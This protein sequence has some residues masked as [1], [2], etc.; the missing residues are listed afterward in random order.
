MKNNMKAY[1]SS[2]VSF[3]LGKL[4]D[5]IKDIDNIILYGSVAKGEATRES[6]V[7]IFIDTKKNLKGEIENIIEEFY[8]SREAILF[9]LQDI[10]NEISVK[11]GELK[12]WKELHRSIASTGIVL[13]GRFEAKEK[14]IGS[15]HRIIF[16][17]DRIGKSRGAFLN[18]I[19]G[20]KGKEKKYKGLIA[21]WN[22]EKT[23]KSCV[24]IPIRYKDEMVGLIKKY[25]VNAKNIEVFALK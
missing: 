4:S 3:L 21:E 10:E 25:N 8:K 5:K 11:V 23:G 14:P 9:K 15:E 1:A 19:Y 24:M 22:G 12:K 20:F 16:Y 13:W 18:K 7:D 2:F 6:D 17:W